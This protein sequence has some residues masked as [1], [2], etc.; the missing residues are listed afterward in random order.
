MFII[1]DLG[2]YIKK[3]L[4]VVGDIGF[5]T[6]SITKLAKNQHLFFGFLPRIGV[7]YGFLEQYFFRGGFGNDRFAFG[8]GYEY[9]LIK[10]SDSHIDYS[11]SLDWATQSSH[12]ISYAYQF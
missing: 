12:T 6:D 7:E 1:F 10:T 4:M 11:F 9:S 2:Q 8:F 3:D 5:I